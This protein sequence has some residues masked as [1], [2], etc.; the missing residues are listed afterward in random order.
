MSKY[1]I[2]WVDNEQ[3]HVFG[4]QPDKLDRSTI[5]SP[6]RRVHKRAKVGD[7]RVPDDQGFLHEILV[8]LTGVEELL[9]VGPSTAKLELLRYA[10][11]NDAALEAKIVGVESVER[12]GDAAL[13]DYAQKYF[14]PTSSM[15]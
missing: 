7:S 5:W 1:A 11:Q 13:V 10:R 12:P 9:V 14:A 6:L 15:R 2:V 8:A 4:V 3:A